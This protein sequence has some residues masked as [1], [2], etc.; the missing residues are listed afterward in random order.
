MEIKRFYFEA[1]RDQARII[2]AG[3]ILSSLG[4]MGFS[5]VHY[6]RPQSN[7]QRYPDMEIVVQRQRRLTK[8][9]NWMLH[10]MLTY[11]HR[12]DELISAKEQK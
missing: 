4:K 9:E 8:K 5:I 11:P 2:S 6:S 7:N 1:I 3:D 10:E 12:I